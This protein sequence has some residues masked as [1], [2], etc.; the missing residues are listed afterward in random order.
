MPRLDRRLFVLAFAVLLSSCAGAGDT[1]ARA[2]PIRP[3]RDIIV[4]EQVR[5]F[6]DAYQAIQ[7]LHPTWLRARGPDSFRESSRVWVY[8]DNSRLGG[9]GTLSNVAAMNIAEIRFYDGL[10]ASQRWG[11]GHGAG[12]ISITSRSR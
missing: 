3:S 1:A 2:R 10:E 4:Q 7:A 5:E 12:V 11:L 9:V 8:I 6:T